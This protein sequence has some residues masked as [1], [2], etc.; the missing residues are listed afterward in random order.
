VGLPAA[1]AAR[2]PHE[3]S[4]GQKQRVGIAR[5]L[6]SDPTL[7]IADEP[8]SA[9]DVSIQAQILNLLGALQA[10]RGLAFLFI[11]H[12]LRVVRYLAHRVAVMYLGHLIELGPTEALFA[13]PAH[14]YTRAL[15]AAVPVARPA[16]EPGRPPL[17]VMLEGDPPSPLAPPPGCPFHPRCAIFAASQDPRCREIRPTLVLSPGAAAGHLAA[18]H[19]AGEASPG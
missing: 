19:H 8:V 12:D 3:L 2:F 7:V 11:S 9:L 14:P 16:A 17:R 6:A 1:A 10:Q 18:C 13:R 15:L 5:A 4:G